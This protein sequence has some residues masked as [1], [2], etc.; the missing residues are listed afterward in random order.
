M[1]NFLFQINDVTGD[2][3]DA[4]VDL[5]WGTVLDILQSYR[6]NILGKKLGVKMLEFGDTGFLCLISLG[7]LRVVGRC[8]SRKTPERE[9]EDRDLFLSFV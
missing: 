4:G 2:A 9:P 3:G 8:R 7:F 6:E 1:P 5:F